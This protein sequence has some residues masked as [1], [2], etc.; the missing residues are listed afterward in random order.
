MVIYKLGTN[1]NNTQFFLD[2]RSSIRNSNTIW[3]LVDLLIEYANRSV[4]E[5]EMTATAPIN[6]KI[7][8]DFLNI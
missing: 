5:T 7:N 1:S 2:L 3:W 6:Q 8:L 4:G